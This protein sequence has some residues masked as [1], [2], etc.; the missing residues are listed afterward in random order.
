M[1]AFLLARV[2]GGVE[3]LY[4]KDSDTKPPEAHIA[5]WHHNRQAEI[6]AVV[7]SLEGQPPADRTFR[8]AWSASGTS[9]VVDMPKARNIWR[10]RMR[11]A[12]TPKLA[13]LDI[14]YM[15][16][17]EDGSPT[18]GIVAKKQT[19]RDVTDDPGIEAARTPE[20]LK[21]FWPSCLSTLR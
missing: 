7:G 13:E 12:R 8:G 17:H 19:L 6:A 15:R 9:I 18:A 14:A 1:K 4:T 10:D 20:E 21:Q 5:K 3:I 2:D 11:M 16:A